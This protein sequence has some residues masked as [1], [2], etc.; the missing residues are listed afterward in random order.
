MTAP[1]LEDPQLARGAP[2]SKRPLLRYFMGLSLR[3]VGYGLLWRW[4]EPGGWGRIALVV[5]MVGEV[6]GLA[7]AAFAVLVVRRMVAKLNDASSLVVEKMERGA[8][9]RAADRDAIVVDVRA[10]DAI[11]RP[12]DQR[13]RD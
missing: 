8:A 4:C 10:V 13:I 9:D 7:W 12:M 2:D 3:L 6:L 1:I 5:L 11:D